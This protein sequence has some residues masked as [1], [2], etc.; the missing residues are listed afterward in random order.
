MLL[1]SLALIL[2]VTKY[3][4]Y[5]DTILKYLPIL[6]AYTLLSELL[7][8]IIRDVEEIQIIYKQD[9]YNYNTIIFNIFDII[10]FLYFFYVYYH[11]INNSFSK[12]VIKYGAWVFLATCICNLFFQNFYV[13]PQN[14]A[15]IIG[16]LILL[17]AV[18]AYLHKIFKEERK[19]LPH[20]NLLFWIS[21]GILFFYTWYPVSMYILTFYYDIYSEYNLSVFHYATI[22]VFYSCII[23]GFILM[24]RLRISID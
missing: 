7:G 8:I 24:K 3:Q 1:Y 21:L 2:S 4:L 6:L 18:L 15:I 11:L 12:K 9:F 19:T 20:R 10:F 23:T 13:E 22:G 14:Y 16:A 17:Y 5:Y